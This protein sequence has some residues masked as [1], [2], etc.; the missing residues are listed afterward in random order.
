MS[1]TY[2]MSHVTH[3]PKI[4][5]G[6]DPLLVNSICLSFDIDS[7]YYFER[8]SVPRRKR[9]NANKKKLLKGVTTPEN[10]IIL[11]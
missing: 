2:V 11:P 5:F 3:V 9:L 4:Y 6:E 1:P 7:F 8:V 10:V